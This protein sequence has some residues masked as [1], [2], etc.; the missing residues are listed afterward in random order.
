MIM[1]GSSGT[2]A[3]LGMAGFVAGAQ[4]EHGGEVW[5]LVETTADVAGCVACVRV[6]RTDR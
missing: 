3:L 4:I 1:D 5:V 6:P 2:T